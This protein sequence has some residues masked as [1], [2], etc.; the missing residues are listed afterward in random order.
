[1]CGP[2]GVGILYGKLGHLKKMKPILFGGGMNASF[3]SDQ[4]RVYDDVP[5]CFEAG[6]PNVEGIL[7]F[8]KIIEYLNAIGMDN[9]HNYVKDLRKYAIERFK[10]IDDIVLYNENFDSNL[11]T[12]NKVGVFAQ[13][14]SIYLSRKIFV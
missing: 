13:D 7:A 5:R 12:F 9:I 10:E 14:L 3:A 2:T 11:I 6:T 8:G 1:M 4:T